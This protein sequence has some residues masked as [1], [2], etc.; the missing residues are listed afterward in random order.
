LSKA[1]S[2]EETPEV[3]C[4]ATI[5]LNYAKDS[6]LT[7]MKR[8]LIEEWGEITENEIN[9]VF[10]NLYSSTVLLRD[11]K[12]YLKDYLMKV[13]KTY[14]FSSSFRYHSVIRAMQMSY[15]CK[16]TSMEKTDEGLSIREMIDL[17]MNS[18]VRTSFVNMFDVMIPIVNEYKMT[19]SS[20]EKMSKKSINRHPKFRTLTFFT[21]SISD[22]VKERDFV[23]AIF[24]TDADVRSS[25]LYTIQDFSKMLNVDA[26]S[27]MTEPFKTS[28]E[29]FGK[30]GLTILINY[31]RWY[32]KFYS[33]KD[34][35]MVSDF[36]TSWDRESDMATLYYYK[37]D[38]EKIY[39][40]DDLDYVEDSRKMMENEICFGTMKKAATHKIT[41]TR[42]RRR[43]QVLKM[44][45][46]ASVT[47]ETLNEANLTLKD[48]SLLDSRPV[49]SRRR[50][51]SSET[52][53]CYLDSKGKVTLI[54]SHAN[55]WKIN[56]YGN[57]SENLKSMVTREIIST[58][59]KTTNMRIFYKVSKSEEYECTASELLSD[60]IW[61]SIYK[62][63]F[64]RPKMRV[65]RTFGMWKA[66]LISNNHEVNLFKGEKN[67][68]PE[69]TS[70]SESTQVKRFKN[71]A[72]NNLNFK[73]THDLIVETFNL[74][75][76]FF[77]D[78]VISKEEK[79]E[80]EGQVESM[81][82]SSLIDS[83]GLGFIDDDEFAGM[84]IDTMSDSSSD[85]QEISDSL[86]NYWEVTT[87]MSP[88]FVEEIIQMNLRPDDSWSRE[89]F[90][91]NSM[92][93]ESIAIV[94]REE[95]RYSISKFC[96]PDMSAQEVL[97]VLSNSIVRDL[98]FEEKKD[99]NE[100]FAVL[101]G[102]A[103]MKMSSLSRRMVEG[104]GIKRISDKA[105]QYIRG[106]FYWKREENI[107][108]LLEELRA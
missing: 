63:Y 28:K 27:L 31:I 20:M 73:Q 95:V 3:V 98:W 64:T 25:M 8:N 18:E 36:A 21:R 19:M 85:S 67:F 100:F 97:T 58:D 104:M 83:S 13:K 34:V 61:S 24:S 42:A 37:T 94:I 66:D 29:K 76:K 84:G 43:D 80:M 44:I 11:F 12:M 39:S 32:C 1:D 75:H 91:V 89:C 86:D 6:N 65:M 107:E 69:V 33:S 103:V 96:R 40:D 47:S 9:H 93:L 105:M 10:L 54:E 49:F 59:R 4:K 30:K 41:R 87:L 101:C 70:S 57:L 53:M 92:I 60:E 38:P 56:M 82:V 50:I 90:E 15:N 17:I 35:T 79:Q 99:M 71:L 88:E 106:S 22:R 48:L 16:L 77:S 68:Y 14:A 52:E 62:F 78:T 108:G 72:M 26:V 5:E 2:L 23:K 45:S 74:D 55:K 102:L 51:T 46:E 81:L 7:N